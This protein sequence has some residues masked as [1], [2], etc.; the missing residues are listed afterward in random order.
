MNSIGKGGDAMVEAQKAEGSFS[1][2]DLEG[3]ELVNS[4]TE[5]RNLVSMKKG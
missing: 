5:I 4:A 1:A 3:N 2:V